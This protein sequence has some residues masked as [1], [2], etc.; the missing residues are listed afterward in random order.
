MNE[1]DYLRNAKKTLSTKDN[2]LEHMAYGLTTESAEIMDALKKHKFYG[3]ELNIRNIKEECGDLMWYLYQ[4]LEEIGYT[5]DECR[6]DNIIKLAK[7]YPDKFRDTV[8]R[9][10]DFELSHI[11]TN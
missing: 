7:R 2:L 4:M 1:I 5:P 9:D 11:G 3:R 10:E 8:D 6:E